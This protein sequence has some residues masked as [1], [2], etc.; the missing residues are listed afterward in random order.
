[1]DQF[2]SRQRSAQAVIEPRVTA[3][4]VAR[5]VAGP[6]LDLCLR[7]AMAEPWIDDIIIVD[8]GLNDEISSWLRALQADRRDVHIVYAETE[9]SA[10]AASNRGAEN[11]RGRWILFLDPNVVLQRGAVTRMAAA[12][13]GV[14]A[15]WI[16]GGRLTD[17]NGRERPA[18]RAGRLTAWSAVA[19]ALDWPAPK[20]FRPRRR[21]DRNAPRDP[22]KVAAVSSSLMLIPRGDFH[23]LQGFD[24]NFVTHAADLDLCRRASDAGGSVL[25]QPEAG[26]VQFAAPGARRRE[27]QGLAL[28]MSKSAKTPL[29]KAFALIAGPAFAVLVAARDLVAGRPPI[30]R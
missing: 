21:K 1:V 18:V 3:V 6:A 12:G 15:P 8:Q 17:L 19:L 5:N 13:G 28:F 14:A 11:A 7:S 25:F 2:P 24:E 20:P 4:V 22:A 29:E 9:L 27:A 16:V 26:G 10:A 23:G 30:R